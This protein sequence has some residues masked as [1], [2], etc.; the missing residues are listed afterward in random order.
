MYSNQVVA[1]IHVERT[2]QKEQKNMNIYPLR[3]IAYHQ[4]YPRRIR[5]SLA[6]VKLLLNKYLLNITGM[7]EE[8]IRL[9]PHLRR[10]RE[11][12]ALLVRK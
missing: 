6:L 3:T 1:L 8:T 5:E 11:G 10:I 7:E 4:E 12:L 2:K 9:H